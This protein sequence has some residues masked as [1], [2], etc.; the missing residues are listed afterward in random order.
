M[1]TIEIRDRGTFI[2]ALAVRVDGRGDPLLRRAGFGDLPLVI[3]VHLE[4]LRV[5]WDPYAW[6][7]ITMRTAHL[8]L[9]TRWD[10]VPDGGVVDSEFLRGERPKPRESELG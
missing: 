2:P 3:L 5:E 1:K 6:D 10:E 7:N 9:A 8:H 4:G